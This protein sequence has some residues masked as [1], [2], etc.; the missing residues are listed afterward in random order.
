M[1]GVAGLMRGLKL[2]D[3]ERKGARIRISGKEKGKAATAQAVGK[4]M[5][6]R[7]AHPDAICLTLGKIWCP[8]KGTDCKEIGVNQFL[9][10]FHQETGKRKALDNGPWMFDKDLVVIEDYDPSK[11]PEDYQFNNIP[12]WARV[13]TYPLV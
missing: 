12:I 13:L 7:L 4:V 5:S 9:F 11:R 3:E 10:T 2:S 1:E 8:I 6:E